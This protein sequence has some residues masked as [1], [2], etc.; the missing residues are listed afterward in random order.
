MAIIAGQSIN[1]GLY[2]NNISLLFTLETA[3]LT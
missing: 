1:I 2:G 3:E